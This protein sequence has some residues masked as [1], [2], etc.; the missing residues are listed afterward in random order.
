MNL[1]GT[2]FVPQ[3]IYMNQFEGIVNRISAS[4]G[5]GFTNF[6]L[7]PERRKHNKALHISMEIAKTTLSR[8]LVDTCSSLNVFPKY[9]LLKIDYDG[10]LLR[11]SDLI[12]KAFDGSKRTVFGEVDLPIKIGPQV[13]KATFFIMDN[14]PSSC[15]LLGLPWIHGAGAV[16]STMH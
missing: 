12:V 1:L 15:Y 5:L 9:S 4:N 14:N 7:P 11:P 16:T 6:H 8:V 13:F 3:E 10:L 2:S